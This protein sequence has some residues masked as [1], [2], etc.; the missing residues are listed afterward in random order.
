MYFFLQAGEPNFS[1][2]PP[3]ERFLVP[4]DLELRLELADLRLRFGP[5]DRP[6]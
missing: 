2:L 6:P 3:D 1:F 4:R 5:D